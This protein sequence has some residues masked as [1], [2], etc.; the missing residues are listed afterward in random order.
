VIAL[1]AQVRREILGIDAT[2]ALAV[3]A[4]ILGVIVFT[5]AALTRKP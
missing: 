5:V 3:A 2:A 4:V 1:V